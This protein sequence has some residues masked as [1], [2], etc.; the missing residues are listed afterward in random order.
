MPDEFQVI[1]APGRGRTA[2]LRLRG[3]LDAQTAPLLLEKSAEV[4][5]NGQNLVLNLAEVSFVG[6]S[7]IGALLILVEQFEEQSGAVRL[8]A[9]SPAVEA[10]V[11]LLS[12]EELLSIDRTEDEALAALER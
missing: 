4:Q 2:L 11:R 12:L 7:G 10:V 6:S 8:A 9:L 5:A 1:S 3:T